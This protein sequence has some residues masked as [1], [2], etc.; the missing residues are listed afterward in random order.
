MRKARP[1]TY[2]VAKQAHVSVSTVSRVINGLAG[3]DDQTRARVWAAI[4]ELGYEVV[5]K[6]EAL[7]GV[8]VLAPT[9][10]FNS[11]YWQLVV[12]GVL[13]EAS[14]LGVPVMFSPA[15][16]REEAVEQIRSFSSRDGILG[17]IMACFPTQQSAADWLPTD[18]ETA[19]VSVLMKSSGNRVNIDMYRATYK[20]TLSLLQQGHR[21]IDIAINSLAWWAQQ[22]RLQGYLDAYAKIGLLVPDLAAQRPV[23]NPN[24]KDWLDSRLHAADAPTAII[25]GT[26]ELS[27]QI[28][29]ELHRM[30]VRIP[31]DLSFIG[32][33]HQRPWVEPLFDTISQPTFELGIEAVRALQSVVTRPDKQVVTSLDATMVRVGSTAR[34]AEG[35]LAVMRSVR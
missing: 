25:G 20:A 34:P 30:Q 1:S 35:D 3:V 21:R 10:S 17:V 15:G 6:P 27:N 4:R 8:L 7:S 26:S 22:Q 12:S 2:D 33:G 29:A 32:I 11:T 24:V 9:V 23:H 31:D 14:R 16:S 13:E 28:F 19:S 5:R 18:L